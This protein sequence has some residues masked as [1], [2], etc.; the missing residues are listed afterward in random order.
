MTRALKVYT[1]TGHSSR[2]AR[3]LGDRPHISQVRCTVAA[4]TQK[5]AA[6]LLGTTPSDMR[7][8]GGTLSLD[9][10]EAATAL[11]SPGQVFARRL[12]DYHRNGPAIKVGVEVGG[13]SLLPGM[14]TD[15][16]HA[17]TVLAHAEAEK[18]RW[19]AEKA[20]R[21]AAMEA[22]QA[23]REQ[24]WQHSEDLLEWARPL[25]AELGVHPD[26]LDVG[27]NGPRIGVLLPPETVAMLVEQI[28]GVRY[29]GPRP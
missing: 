2:V 12:D 7:H 26:T 19:A 20:E 4:H 3:A 5:E 1:Y 25:L 22:A 8:F 13:R 28:M 9:H 18:A 17:A 23:R 10:E 15:L 6:A 16:E 24:H 14:E 27:R 21:A 11:A 29:P